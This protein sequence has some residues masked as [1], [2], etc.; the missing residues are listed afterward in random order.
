MFPLFLKNVD[1]HNLHCNICEFA[2][3]HCIFFPLSNTRSSSPFSLIHF[4]IWGPYKIPK[5]S[6][7]KWF[8]SFIDYCTRV[9]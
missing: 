2:K 1:I 3:P 9:T 6:G 4:D 7:A 5:I 8:V